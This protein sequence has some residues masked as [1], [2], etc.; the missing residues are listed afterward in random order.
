VPDIV[1]GRVREND[2]E[3]GSVDPTYARF[4]KKLLAESVG[5]EDASFSS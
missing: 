2:M 1:V 3:T 5:L 4:K